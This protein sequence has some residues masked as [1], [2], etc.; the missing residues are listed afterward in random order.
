MIDR[1]EHAV[2]VG[3]VDFQGDR[4]AV[5]AAEFFGDVA[6]GLGVQIGDRDL[7]AVG[8]QPLG[9]GLSDALTATCD[10]SDLAVL[11]TCHFCYSCL[12]R[13]NCKPFHRVHHHA[14]RAAIVLV[15][16]Q[17]PRTQRRIACLRPPVEP[18]DR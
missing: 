13:A 16:F 8:V 3:D 6:G 4:T 15:V 11:C 10:Q 17:Q 1:R 12:T 7:E 2:P 9:D 14:H 18:F 5:L